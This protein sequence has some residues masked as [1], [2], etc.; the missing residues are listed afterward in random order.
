MTGVH[1]FVNF[2]P[3]LMRVVGPVCKDVITIITDEQ[4]YFCA[5]LPP[6]RFL[7]PPFGPL[8]MRLADLLKSEADIK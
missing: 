1:G 3:M 2:F 7:L 5:W 8:S 4:I 6:E